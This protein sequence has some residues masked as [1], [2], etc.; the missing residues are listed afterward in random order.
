MAS[1]VPQYPFVKGQILYALD[2]LSVGPDAHLRLSKLETA[3]KNIASNDFQDFANVIEQYMFVPLNM[4]ESLK[5]QSMAHIQQQWLDPSSAATYFPDHQ[6]IAPTFAS[7]MLR[8]VSVSLAGTGQPKPID[9]WWVLGHKTF[10]V[11]T[12]VSD[13]QVTMLLCTP[14]PRGAPPSGLWHPSA[15]GYVTGHHGVV[16]RQYSPPKT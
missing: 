14:S 6:P 15:E 16:T 4:T 7:G 13:R 11:M 12:L 9:A 8:T 3:L 1:F 2:L 5:P 10:E